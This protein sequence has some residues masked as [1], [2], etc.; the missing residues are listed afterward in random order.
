MKVIDRRPWAP[1]TE[2]LVWRADE[3][4]DEARTVRASD[5]E[6]AAEDWADYDDSDSADYTIIDGDSVTVCVCEA[7][8]TS[9]ARRFVVRGE[10]VAQYTAREE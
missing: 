6:R 10:T 7:I 1:G 2:W 5:A 9:A 8:L 4:E 3:T